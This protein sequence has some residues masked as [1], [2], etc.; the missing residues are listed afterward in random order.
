MIILFGTEYIIL[1]LDSVPIRL[2]NNRVI[3]QKYEIQN[4]TI[5]AFKVYWLYRAT[6]ELKGVSS[7]PI[8]ENQPLTTCGKSCASST[9]PMIILRG[10]LAGSRKLM[11]L[12]YSCCVVLGSGPP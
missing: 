5:D 1:H 6:S 7:N 2:C 9:F 4:Y 11:V 3:Q 12:N 10:Q 8:W